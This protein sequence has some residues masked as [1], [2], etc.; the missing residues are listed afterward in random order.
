MCQHCG[1]SNNAGTLIHH[2]RLIRSGLAA[3]D[4]VLQW[5][6]LYAWAISYESLCS[7][8]IKGMSLYWAQ[9]GLKLGVRCRFVFTTMPKKRS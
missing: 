9:K 3:N 1:G 8:G 6:I 7:K 4:E 2:S 5:R